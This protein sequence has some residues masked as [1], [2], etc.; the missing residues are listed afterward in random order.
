MLSWH[1]IGWLPKR[2]SGFG[3]SK[4]SSKTMQFWSL[5]ACL[6]LQTLIIQTQSTRTG[7]SGS[8]W[9]QQFTSLC[10]C[11]QSP[12]LPFTFIWEQSSYEHSLCILMSLA[13]SKVCNSVWYPD[14]SC[15]SQGWLT[16][17]LGCAKL[18]IE[19]RGEGD[20]HLNSYTVG[21]GCTNQISRKDA[22][23]TMAMILH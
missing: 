16:L 2:Q 10:G 5:A 22:Q 11:H 7:L 20:S 23:L 8:V 14:R 12:H 17:N 18:L 9:V 21:F 6:T 15:A 4:I 1:Q 3:L 19:S 13:S